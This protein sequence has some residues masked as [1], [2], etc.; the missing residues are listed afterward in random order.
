MWSVIGIIITTGGT[1]LVAWLTAKAKQGADEKDEEAAPVIA[2]TESR[3]DLAAV[4][5]HLASEMGEMRDE[6][7][8]LKTIAHVRY[9]LALGTISSF[10]ARHPDS[11]VSIPHQIRGDL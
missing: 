5:K 1:V 9:P 11:D 7:D 8:G 3:R 6:I 10:R 2:D 4:V